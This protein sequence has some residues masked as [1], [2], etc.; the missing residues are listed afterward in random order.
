MSRWVATS[1]LRRTR[2]GHR[3]HGALA[4]QS[5]T[6]RKSYPTRC[7]R[8]LQAAAGTISHHTAVAFAVKIE[9]AAG[10]GP[11][12][13]ESNRGQPE[14]S[15]A[16]QAAQERRH[17]GEGGG[18]RHRRRAAGQIPA[19]RQ[20]RGRRL[21]GFGF[22]DW[23][24]AGTSRRHLHNTTSHRLQHGFPDAL[25]Q[26]DSTPRATCPGTTTSPSSWRVLN[27]AARRTPVPAQTLKRVLARPRSS[28][29]R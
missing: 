21:R 6:R 28:A 16:R 8:R 17:Q 10:V 14:P 9:R 15:R 27:T 23:C 19:H 18:E 20:V 4:P 7:S 1:D 5:P 11:A 25:A 29:S 24:S 12:G 13:R 3:T 22:C 26:L 2:E